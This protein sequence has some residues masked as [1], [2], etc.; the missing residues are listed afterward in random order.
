MRLNEFRFENDIESKIDEFGILSDKIDKVKKELSELSNRYKEIEG[1]LRP[2]LEQLTI[3]NKKSIQTKRYLVTLKRMGYN[4]DNFKYKESFVESLTK[5]NKQTKKVLEDI[6][7][8]TK[9]VSRV[10]S[11]IGVQRMDEISLKSMLKKLIS[12]FKKL[13]SRL[14]N[15]NKSID[16]LNGVLK[17]M[18]S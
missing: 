15:T 14:K 16:G 5:V 2:T 1:E 8:S 7:L 9:T 11:T 4:R 18:V 17:R 3:Q 13:F 10:V 6:L 12:P